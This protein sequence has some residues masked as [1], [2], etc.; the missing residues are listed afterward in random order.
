MNSGTSIKTPL[1]VKNQAVAIWINSYRVGA[2]NNSGDMRNLG[3]PVSD[4]GQK[5]FNRRP[6]APIY[7][8]V[9]LWFRTSRES[10]GSGG[11]RSRRGRET[12]SSA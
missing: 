1:A 8:A 7:V 9:I 3:F 2:N 4:P 11:C 10:C 12:A 6:V 5:K